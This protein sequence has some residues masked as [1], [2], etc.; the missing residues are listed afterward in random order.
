LGTPLVG[1]LGLLRL[2]IGAGGVLLMS[3]GVCALMVLWLNMRSSLRQSFLFKHASGFLRNKS[4]VRESLHEQIPS[5]MINASTSIPGESGTPTPGKPSPGRR[6][7]SAAGAGKPGKLAAA[8]AG[9]SGTAGELP[10]PLPGAPGW[11]SG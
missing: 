5:Q 10:A 1:R 2:M 11:I 9:R 6:R 4:R 8:S 3:Y 7:T